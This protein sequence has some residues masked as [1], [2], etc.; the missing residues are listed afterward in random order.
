[1]SDTEPEIAE[2][3]HQ[4]MM[5]RAGAERMMM[6]S[7]MFDTAKAMIVASLPAG[8]TPLEIKE[9]LCQRLYENEIDVAPCIQ[10]LRSRERVKLLK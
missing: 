2:L 6:G 1:M 3:V 8:L 4:R 10:H 9:Q 5:E 7:R